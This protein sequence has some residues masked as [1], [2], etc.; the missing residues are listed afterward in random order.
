MTCYDMEMGANILTVFTQVSIVEGVLLILGVPDKVPAM[1]RQYKS[2]PLKGRSCREREPS[3]TKYCELSTGLSVDLR[4][5]I[6]T[7]CELHIGQGYW[8]GH[9]TIYWWFAGESWCD[10]DGVRFLMMLSIVMCSVSQFWMQSSFQEIS[11]AASA[12]YQVELAADSMEEET[13]PHFFRR[14]V[15]NKKT[16]PEYH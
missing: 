7:G 9:W 10:N 6:G 12:E 15:G 16:S 5:P 1:R 8:D 11:D 14:T 3:V 4:I 13:Q 2:P